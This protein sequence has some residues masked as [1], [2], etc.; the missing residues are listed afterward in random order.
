MERCFEKISFEQFKKDIIDSRELY[1]NYEL[2]V[3]K[4]KYSAGYDF[5]AMQDFEIKPG[6]IK[7]IPTGYKAKFQT[8]EMLLILVRSS[9]GFKYNVRLCNQV[10]LIESDYYNNPD[11][12]GH[13]FVKLQN[14]GDK[15]F[16]VKKGEGYAQGIFTKFLTCGDT[17]LSERTGGIGS[18][19]KK[20]G[21]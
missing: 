12:E 19:N 21:N 10:G 11:N 4:T 9:M 8:D 5:I 6:E 7:K 3:R 1:D 14:E 16:S 15:V 17:P 13:L 18:T 20:E 2:P